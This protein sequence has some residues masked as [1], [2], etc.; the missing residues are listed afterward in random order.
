MKKIL[1]IAVMLLTFIPCHADS[2]DV[3]LRLGYNVGGTMPLGLPA[4]IRSIDAFNLTPSLMVGAD[5]SMPLDDRWGVTTGLRLENK[6]MDAEITVKSYRMEM[7]KGS[8]EISGLFTGHVK[9]EVS[10]WM[11]TVPLQVT[12]HL[13]EKLTLKVGPYVSLLLSKD[14]SGIAFDGYIRQGNPTGP[15][16][17]IGSTEADRATYDFSD[18]MRTLQ[19]G[20]GIGLDWQLSR[21]LGLSADL[22]WGLS[23]LFQSSFTTV[24]QTL[25]PIYGTLGVFCQF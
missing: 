9:Q 2:L 19:W 10:Q 7:K 18:D 25:Y 6:G 21:R 16:I 11:L 22:D 17:D 24:E 23:G 3:K 14:F 1:F 13:D 15:R 8:S 12:C 5:V 20:V 4:S